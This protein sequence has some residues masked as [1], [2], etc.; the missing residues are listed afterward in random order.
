LQIFEFYL[1]FENGAAV[2]HCNGNSVNC[3]TVYHESDESML[4][5]LPSADVKYRSNSDGETNVCV[6]WVG[7]SGKGRL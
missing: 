6:A 1:K 3:G 4:A 7:V 2:L 5:V